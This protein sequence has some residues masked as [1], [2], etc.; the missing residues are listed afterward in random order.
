MSFKAG[1]ILAII[2]IINC[3][4]GK[5]EKSKANKVMEKRVTDPHSFSQPEE[6]VVKHMN[7]DLQ[8]DFDKKI[9]IGNAEIEIERSADAQNLIL[10]TKE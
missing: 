5:N 7:L 8:V 1:I 3:C 2:I 6:A 10:D 9:I 4:Q